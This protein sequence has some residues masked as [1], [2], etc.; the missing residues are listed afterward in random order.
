MDETESLIT[1]P[2]QFDD[3]VDIIM[4][5]HR[6]KAEQYVAAGEEGRFK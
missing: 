3:V 5:E 1:I 2:E 6:S 4:S